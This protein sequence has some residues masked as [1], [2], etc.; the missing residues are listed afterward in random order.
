MSHNPDE[1]LTCK[2]AKDQTEEEDQADIVASLQR[3][4]EALREHSM[5]LRP[6]P[7]PRRD[8]A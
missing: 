4:V 8:T 2:A 5:N 7:P 1:C 3:R 6:T